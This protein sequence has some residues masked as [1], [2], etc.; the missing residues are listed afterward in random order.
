[1]KT[2]LCLLFF[3]RTEKEAFWGLDINEHAAKLRN[4]D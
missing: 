2:E 3:L 4:D 1:M